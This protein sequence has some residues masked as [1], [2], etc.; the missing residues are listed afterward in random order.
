MRRLLIL[1]I[2]LLT[3][4]TRAEDWIPFNPK[5][6]PF[7]A[8]NA[9]DLR[10]LNEMQA[11]DGGFI[12]TRGGQFVHSKT[13]EPVR[14][15]AV[16]G[17][18]GESP[19]ELRRAAR[20]L[21]KRGVNLVRIH[22]GY[23]SPDGSV[24]PK[25]IS[26]AIDIVQALKAEGIYSHFSIYFPLWLSPK[27]GTP[28]LEGYNGG[29]HPFAALTFNHDFQQK[30]R[31]WWKALLTTPGADG[32]KLVNDPAVFGAEIINEDSYFFWTFS[33]ANLPEPQMRML[34]TQFGEWLKKQHG[35]VEAAFKA[36]GGTKTPRDNA[37]EGRAGF[38]GLWEMAN[39]RT[40]RDK[41]TARFLLE[42]QRGF[43]EAQVKFLREIGFKGVV[44]ASNWTT[45]DARVLGPLEKYSYSPGDFL[46]R[47]GYFGC[48]NKGDSAEWSLR[49]GH[50]FIDRSALR[51][52]PEQPGKPKD[53]VNTIMD[54]HYDSKPS[55]VSEMTFNRPSRFRSEAPLYYACY[56]ALQGSDAIVHFAFDGSDWSVKPG[57][58]MQPWTL[59][60]PAMMGQFPAA[61]LIYRKGL[62]WPGDTVVDLNLKLSDLL[63]L[64]GTPMPQDAAFDALRLAIGTALATDHTL[65]GLC[66][67][68]TPEAPEPVLLAIDGNEGLKAA[69]IPVILAYATSDPL[70]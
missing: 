64:T 4:P 55:M 20:V 69:V 59:M 1:T 18:P 10:G 6:D 33:T 61:A 16:N 66:D 60:T 46:D 63:D 54:I 62:V 43:Y 31:E 27:P 38:R 40:E 2:G 58:W 49:D 19:A 39:Q 47:H 26:H 30:Y 70:L 7:S 53:F 23:F 9:I 3:L 50:T 15:W 11:G 68:I 12:A 14:F 8:A 56:G 41:E 22:G 67:H 48:L 42:S 65:G 51:F 57:Y 52:E 13:N 44:T 21:A 29:Q 5:P 24:D 28:W 25:K 17:C 36:W 34:E 37:A 35:S 32:Y 45:A